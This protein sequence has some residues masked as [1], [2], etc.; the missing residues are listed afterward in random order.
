MVF[1][2]GEIELST[3]KEWGEERVP[4]QAMIQ[5]AKYGSLKFGETQ[6]NRANYQDKRSCG[7]SFLVQEWR[8][9]IY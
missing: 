6:L 4:R 7:K 3:G 5:R 2:C 1:V 8:E 9:W